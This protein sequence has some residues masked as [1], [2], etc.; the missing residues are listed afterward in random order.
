M[1][2][3]FAA[4]HHGSSLFVDLMPCCLPLLQDVRA[5]A[6]CCCKAAS[7]LH[8][9]GVVHRD[10]RLDNVAQLGKHRYMLLDLETAA[11]ANARAL[12]STF[13]PFTGWGNSVLDSH[14]RF[15][16]MSDMHLIGALLEEVFSASGIASAAASRALIDKLKR[17]LLSA[18]AALNDPWLA[19]SV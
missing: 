1:W 6:I 10:I 5:L 12:P 4:L 17:K 11:A 7:L 15:T 13:I 9:A 14:K 8:Q 3:C 16:T 18:T 2:Q 19:Q